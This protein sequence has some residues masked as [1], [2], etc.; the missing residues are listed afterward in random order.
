VADELL[1]RALPLGDQWSAYGADQGRGISV[2]GL[3]V[4][5]D[6]WGPRDLAMTLKRDPDTAFGDLQAATPLE[7]EIGNSLVWAGRSKETPTSEI[8]RQIA[9]NGEGWQYHL[10]DDDYRKSYVHASLTDW[11]D[12]RS[13]QNCDLTK[14]TSALQVSSDVGGITLTIPANVVRPANTGGGIYLDC[15]PDSNGWANQVDVTWAHSNNSVGT[16]L[17]LC[18]ASSIATLSTMAGTTLTALNVNP[19]SS[20][21][22]SIAIAGPY[23]YLGLFLVDNTGANVTFTGVEVTC[24]LTA[25]GVYS[26]TAYESGGVSNLGAPAI[27][28]DALA[29]A[30][31]LNQSTAAISTTA[32]A[33]PDFSASGYQSPRSYITAANAYHAYQAR[34]RADKV[35]EF[36]PRPTAPLLTLVNGTLEN[37]SA[38]SIAE[39]YNKCVGEAT[40]PD[41]VSIISTQFGSGTIPD[42][43]G[44]YRTNVLSSNMSLTQ[45]ALDQLC[46]TFISGH[47][48]MPFKGTVTVSGNT[49]VCMTVG[50]A[51]VPPWE[52]LRYVGELLHF[53]NLV[54]PDTGAKG[55]DGRIA[56][57]TYDHDS[58]TASVSI[59]SQRSNFEAL[60]A[61]LQVVTGRVA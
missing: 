32:F 26:S 44:Y 10:D 19:T 21:N 23:R 29:K 53:P 1:V 47:G 43:R 54:D 33:I 46:Q 37:A 45:T 40:G 58:R 55:R 38:G 56:A 36:R 8:N 61:R 4:G 11:Q 14:K 24:K 30:P 39:V 20:A 13:N 16:N 17:I 35:L 22:T 9:V 25:I 15:G 34:V 42:R 50:G 7:V 18:Y 49:A 51:S 57:V 48:K 41:G 3:V 59:D 6:D 27:I 12:V 31:L 60:L 5:V 52:L 28:M 2:E